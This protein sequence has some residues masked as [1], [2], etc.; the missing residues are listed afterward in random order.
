LNTGSY[1]IIVTAGILRCFLNSRRT[2]LDSMA[3]R[4]VPL[5]DIER[6]WLILSLAAF[7]CV[8]SRSMPLGAAVRDCRTAVAA[9]FAFII[10]CAG[11]DGIPFESLYL[12]PVC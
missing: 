10:Y 3:I 5:G 9:D 12:A 6:F 4:C 1:N 7:Y 2:S 11:R 8:I